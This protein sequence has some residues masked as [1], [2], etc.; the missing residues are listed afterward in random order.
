MLIFI[1]L[2]LQERERWSSLNIAAL[3]A[4]WNQTS[5][6][7]TEAIIYL[8]VISIIHFPMT[9]A[10]SSSLTI[11]SS[12]AV[13]S[14]LCFSPSRAARPLW[15]PRVWSLQL[16]SSPLRCLPVMPI[17]EEYLHVTAKLFKRATK[18]LVCVSA[19]VVPCCCPVLSFHDAKPNSNV[20]LVDGLTQG[21][22][23]GI[24]LWAVP[25]VLPGNNEPRL[26]AL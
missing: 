26:K 14:L 17:S 12:S 15:F 20:R 23:V 13:M 22:N 1:E 5:R 16:E 4:Q 7:D 18:Y 3:H 11:L 25:S 9:S 10:K 24:S 19:A 6:A 2:L 8:F 21:T